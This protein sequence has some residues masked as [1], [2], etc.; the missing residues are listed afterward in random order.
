LPFETLEEIRMVSNLNDE[1]VPLLHVILSGQPNLIKR[2]N[3][4]KLEQLLQR[5]AVHYHLESL[6]RN[7]TFQYIKHRL[8]I[9]GSPDPDLFAEEA[10]DSIYA[11]SNGVPRVIN[12]ICD[13]ALVCGFA[14]Q[15]K[16]LDRNVIE[17]VVADRLKMGL[18][19]GGRPAVPDRKVQGQSMNSHGSLEKNHQELHQRVYEIAQLVHKAVGLQE[20]VV[21]Q[22]KDQQR[23]IERLK[24]KV[25]NLEKRLP[26][27]PY[28]K[29]IQSF[30]KKIGPGNRL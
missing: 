14:G 20:T 16:Q 3:D 7:E 5:V 28:P 10:F 2:L 9:V 25:E 6:N 4:P 19:F 24:Q 1:K 22:K 29:R 13:T 12:L 26:P 21:A 30:L 23:E 15:L 11:H 17:R 8:Q 18:G 27:D